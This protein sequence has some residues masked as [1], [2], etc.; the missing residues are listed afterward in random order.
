MLQTGSFDQL[1]MFVAAA[2]EG[3]FSAAARLVRRTQSAVSEAI[4]NLE[5]QLGVVLFDRTGR[6]P[7]LTQEGVILLADARAVITDVDSMKARAKGIAGGLQAELAAAGDPFL[8][9]AHGSE[10]LRAV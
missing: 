4:L 2:D 5:A 1:R 9:I 3:S 8:A 6:Y 10:H 7:K